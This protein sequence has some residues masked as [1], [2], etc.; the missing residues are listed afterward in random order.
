MKFLLILSFIL[1]SSTT[2]SQDWKGIGKGVGCLKI[3][4]DIISGYS[5]FRKYYLKTESIKPGINNVASIDRATGEKY[6]EFFINVCGEEIDSIQILDPN[7]KV[8]ETFYNESK[9]QSI[10]R[11]NNI[12]LVYDVYNWDFATLYKG[13]ELKGLVIISLG[14]LYNLLVN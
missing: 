14:L 6:L 11:Y 13:Y 12:Q 2:Y 5:C 7:K 4:G 8:S 10:R 3:E 1:T 9:T